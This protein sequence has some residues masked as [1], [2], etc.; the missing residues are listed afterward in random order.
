MAEIMSENDSQMF[1]RVVMGGTDMRK[2]L[3]SSHKVVSSQGVGLG[4]RPDHRVRLSRIGDETKINIV[5]E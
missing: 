3:K 1:N 2:V 4:K 5:K